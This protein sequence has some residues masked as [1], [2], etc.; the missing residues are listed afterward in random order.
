MFSNKGKR[1][2]LCGWIAWGCDKG[3]RERFIHLFQLKQLDSVSGIGQFEC[4]IWY[5]QDLMKQ[6]SKV[7]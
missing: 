6:K 5:R 3:A 7:G 1:D 4:K 2:Y